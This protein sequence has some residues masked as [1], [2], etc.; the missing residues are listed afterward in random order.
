MN[1]SKVSILSTQKVID[2]YCEY[3]EAALL[4]YEIFTMPGQELMTS[5]KLPAE[6]TG[7]TRALMTEQFLEELTKKRKNHTKLSKHIKKVLKD[8]ES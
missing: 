8:D 7:M 6:K 2:R 5:M 1:R 4:H 3:V